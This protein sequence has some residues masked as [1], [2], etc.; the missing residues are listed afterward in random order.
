[1]SNVLFP[2]QC[3]IFRISVLTILPRTVFF[4]KPTRRLVFCLVTVIVG[5]AVK[6]GIFAAKNLTSVRRV[7]RA[8]NR[9]PVKCTPLRWKT[10]FLKPPV[11]PHRHGV[12]GVSKDRPMTYPKLS[13]A[14]A[15]QSLDS[16]C[17]KALG[18]KVWRRTAANKVNGKA[19][20]SV[21]DQMMRH[22]PK[23]ATFNS[24]YIN[25]NLE[26][27]VQDAVLD[28]PLEGQLISMLT[29]VGVARDPRACKDMVPEDVWNNLP[30]DSEI[31]A[32]EQERE[33]L[34]AGRYQYKGS[35]HEKEIR[36]LTSQIRRKRTAR[37]QQ[38]QQKY[39]EYYFHNRPT[40]DIEMQ[41][42]DAEIALDG[43]EDAAN[44]DD[45]GCSEPEIDLDIPERKTLADILCK[46]PDILSPEEPPEQRILA[47]EAMV[48]LM[49][50][51]ETSRRGVTGSQHRESMGPTEEEDE[52][53][54]LD[55]DKDDED[56]QESTM[57]H[58]PPTG[59]AT[60]PPELPSPHRQSSSSDHDDEEVEDL[61]PQRMHD[62]QCPCCIGDTRLSYDERTFVYCRT[63]VRN[64]HF[65]RAHLTHLE[66]LLAKGQLVCA[67]PKCEKWKKA[68]G[69]MDEFRNHTAQAHGPR[70]RPAGGAKRN[71][72]P[73]GGGRSRGRSR[74]RLFGGW[75]SSSS[76]SSPSCRRLCMRRGW[77][78][79]SPESRLATLLVACPTH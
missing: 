77:Q 58:S 10:E 18:C 52:E 2:D 13:N 31:E 33:R 48:L 63:T 61:F 78:P 34:K 42:D 15:R 45:G 68:M 57:V 4:F 22:D 44:N 21:R 27:S 17:E 60:P 71:P 51:R 8:R 46:Q 66:G 69:S 39:R 55:D 7:F 43:D 67:H 75:E 16:G 36:A 73:R 6:D 20:D 59:L 9:G 38:V 19:P 23:W 79:A 70:L 47:G 37:L 74:I 54:H 35:E 1:M 29:H 65:D 5:L 32:L 3:P 14:M 64:D 40:W 41:D 25:E 50:R 11:F 30:P 76:S 26:F 72:P 53:F 28:E 24:A 49:D 56:N 12:S 62:R